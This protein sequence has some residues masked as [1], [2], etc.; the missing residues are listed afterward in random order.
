[1]ADE[2]ALKQVLINLVS[3]AVKFSPDRSL[4]RIDAQVTSEHL[5]ISVA[6][7]GAGIAAE[8]VPRALTPFTQLDGSLSRAHEGT[9]LGLP[10][11][12]HLT[13]LHDGALSIESTLGE[14]TVVHVDLPLSR[15]VGKDLASKETA[16]L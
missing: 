5:R 13:D 1:V 8:D 15:V 3:N 16:S 2:R 10:L 12:K 11:A 14:G 4:V 7:Q 9:G 6:D